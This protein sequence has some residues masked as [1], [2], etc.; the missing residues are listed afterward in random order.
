MHVEF[1]YIM[2][3][4]IEIPHAVEEI[5]HITFFLILRL[6]SLGIYLRSNWHVKTYMLLQQCVHIILDNALHVY[7]VITFPVSSGIIQYSLFFIHFTA[8]EGHNTTAS[9]YTM[10]TITTRKTA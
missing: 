5:G 9:V 8:I 1:L 6:S 10:E 2:M 7:A 4:K 3:P